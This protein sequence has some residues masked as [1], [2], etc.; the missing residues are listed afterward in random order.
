VGSCHGRNITVTDSKGAVRLAAHIF[1]ACQVAKL[2]NQNHPFCGKDGNLKK[3]EA[4]ILIGEMVR[5]VQ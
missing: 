5:Y 2:G 4:K 1:F 3:I